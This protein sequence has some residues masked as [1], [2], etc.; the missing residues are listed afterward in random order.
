MVYTHIG[1]YR[2]YYTSGVVNHTFGIQFK[3]AK[4]LGDHYKSSFLEN[5]LHRVL[6]D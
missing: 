4:P 6:V 3:C 1:M 5:F 2:L